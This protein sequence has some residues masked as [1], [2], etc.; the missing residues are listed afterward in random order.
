MS[1]PGDRT[2]IITPRERS[3]P[4]QYALF[5]YAPSRL[6]QDGREIMWFSLGPFVFCL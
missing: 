3:V 1:A 4:A 6:L 5:I 2:A